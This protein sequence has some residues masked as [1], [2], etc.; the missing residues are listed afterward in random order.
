MTRTGP[1]AALLAAIGLWALGMTATA[2]ELV[3]ARDG[4]GVFGMKNTP[5]LPWC[6]FHVHDPDRPLPRRVE[7]G[8][9][10]SLPP[11]AD[12]V[13]LFDGKDLSRWD[14]GDSKL[15]DGTLE[16]GSG[17]CSS[18][19]RFGDCQIHLEWMGPV[20]GDGTWYNQGNNGVFLMGLYEI[21]IFDSLNVKIYPDGMAGAIYGQT[22]PL[23]N[24]C[25]APG[26][27]Q[28]FDIV[29]K[30]PTY[31]GDRQV[32]PP[33]VTVFHNGVLIQHDAPIHG[34]TEHAALPGK[35]PKLLE[36]PLVLSG[37]HCPVRFR[38]IWV[39]PL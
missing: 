32:Q 27:W 8:P 35:A 18:K 36:G 31:E 28:S 29:F 33:R 34:K 17:T 5:V 21:Q 11:P 3:K 20:S 9:P 37:H 10:I 16:A 24:A 23:V 25:R 30:A 13:V 22:P 26:Q 15:V 6:G 7:P 19:A 12:A 2:Q 39:R 1:T 4:S 14:A 38:N